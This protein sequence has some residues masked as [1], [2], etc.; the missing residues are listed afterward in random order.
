[1]E[2][3][4]N[5]LLLKILKDAMTWDTPFCIEDYI[6]IACK[7]AIGKYKVPELIDSQP[8]TKNKL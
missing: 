4:L 1:M 7:C 6:S 3:L 8:D 2:K 5:E